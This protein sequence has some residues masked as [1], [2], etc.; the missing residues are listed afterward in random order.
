MKPLLCLPRP[1]FP[2]PFMESQERGK[3]F[4]F[5][6]IMKTVHYH[7]IDLNRKNCEILKIDVIFQNCCLLLR[8]FIWIV[9]YIWNCKHSL[10]FPPL[11]KDWLLLW[12]VGVNFIWAMSFFFFLSE[13]AFSWIRQI[14][15][16][17]SFLTMDSGI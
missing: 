16:I 7:C 2:K 6:S 3:R 1:T 14:Q 11:G 13:W 8:E 9:I 17:K 12:L 5:N 10:P 4:P 15:F